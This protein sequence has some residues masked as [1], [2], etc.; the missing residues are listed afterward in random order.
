M[1]LSSIT[2]TVL[3]SRQ[4]EAQQRE[5]TI[6][7]DLSPAPAYGDPRLAER[8]AANLIDNA[9]RHNVP[10]GQVRVE[11]GNRYGQPFLTVTNTGPL[12]SPAQ[13]AG[14]FEPFTRLGTERTGDG[15]GLGLSIVNAIARAHDAP[16]SAWTLPEGGLKIQVSF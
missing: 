12:I 15:L 8:L 10:D 6:S 4:P 1:D 13:I 5:L 3:A 16:V 7:H 9:L 11:T 2:A 14:L